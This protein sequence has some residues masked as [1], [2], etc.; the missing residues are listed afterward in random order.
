[1]TG[2]CLPSVTAAFERRARRTRAVASAC[3]AAG[4]LWWFLKGVSLAA[5]AAEIRRAHVPY[6]AA[7]VALSLSGFAFRIWRWRYI[8]SPLKWVRFRSLASAVFMGWAVSAL[9]PGRLGEVARAALLS[10]RED[11]RASA[12]FGTVVLE[13]LLDVLAVLLLVAASLAFVPHLAPGHSQLSLVVAIRTGAWITFAALIG[14][15]AVMLAAHHVGDS[16][17]VALGAWMTGLPGGS[18]RLGWGIIES[19]GSG[20]SGALRGARH[21]QTPVRTR[22]WIAVHTALLWAVICGV[23]ALL[24]RAFDL[25]GSVLQLPLLIFLI[26]LGLS[27]PVPAALGSY[28]AAVQLGL[29]VVFGVSNETAAGYAI[30]SHAVTL[31]PPAVIGVI[32]LA[33]EGLALSML[34]PLTSS[35]RSPG[36]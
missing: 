6:L 19:F 21:D 3:V 10:R 16:L 34:V 35:T 29:T 15:A 31:V 2:S 18:G 20:V 28:H 11:L 17:R 12:A 33:R 5:V 30:V 36:A 24:F 9:L 25:Q 22:T 23:H 4:F 1:M 7:A 27:V 8:V 32:L 26:T 13:R 14:V